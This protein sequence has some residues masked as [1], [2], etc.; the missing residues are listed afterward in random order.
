MTYRW[1]GGWWVASNMVSQLVVG[2][3]VLILSV[4]W[5]LVGLED[6]LVGRK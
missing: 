1:V 5:W 4:G 3:S 2:E 6:L